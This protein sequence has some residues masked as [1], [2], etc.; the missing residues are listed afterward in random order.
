M[1]EDR[2]GDDGRCKASHALFSIRS[3]RLDP[4]AVTAGLGIG[5]SRAWAKD[6]EYLSKVGPRRR[7][8]GMWHLSTE[9]S[10]TSRSPEQQALYL[11][12]L[13]EPRVDFL[14]RFVEDSD[15]LVV[16]KFWWESRDNI[17]GFELSSGTVGRLAA[18]SNFIGFT[19]IGTCE[20]EEG[21]GR[22]RCQDP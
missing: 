7:P 9:G 3:D 18:I 16:V 12:E 11:L 15:Y 8:W 22:K 6:E 17:G 10:V 13:L 5:P 19:V 4:A 2:C 14:R 20:N 21:A 1:F